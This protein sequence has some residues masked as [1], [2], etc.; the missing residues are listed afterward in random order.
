MELYLLHKIVINTLNSL[1][2]YT[3]CYMYPV[4]FLLIFKSED[5]VILN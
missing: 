1:N 5:M 4:D 2:E 3:M